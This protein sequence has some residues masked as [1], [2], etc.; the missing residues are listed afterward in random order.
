MKWIRKSGIMIVASC[1]AAGV[2]Q[3][4][5]VI[6][7]PAVLPEAMV[8]VTVSDLHG[9]LDGVGGVAAQVSPMMNGMML[10]NMIGMQLGDPGLAGI[11]PGKGLAVV[12]LD[13]T[14]VFAV[15]EVGEAQIGAY[16]NALAPQGLQ[17]KY[18]NELLIVGK[19]AEQVTKGLGMASAIQT[20]L[21]A[22]RS[23]T[24]RIAA[25]P[26]AIIERNN[27]KIQGL[28]QTMPALMGQGMMQ[29]PGT[30]TNA[31]DS[32]MKILEGEL[33]VL[34]SIAG[35]CESV[36]VVLAPENGSLRIDETFVPK[37]GT[38]LATLC[39]AP[40]VNPPNPRL[41]SGMC[42]E[43]MML[44][45]FV[46]GNPDALAAFIAAETEQLVKAMEITDVDLVGLTE[47]MVKWMSLYCGTGCESV[48]FGADGMNINYLFEIGDEA[49]ALGLLK[50]MQQD[51]APF[52]KLYEDMGMPMSFEFKENVREYKGIKIHTLATRLSMEQMAAEQCAQMGSM[53]L[54]NM[55]YDIAV[56]DGIMIYAM[57]DAKIET[58]IDRLKDDTFKATPLKA[59]SVYPEKGFYYFDLDVGEYIDFIAS[60]MP[61]GTPM[62]NPQMVALFQ[63]V[64]PVTSAGFKAD[65]R[66]MWSANVPGELIAKFGQMAMMAQMQQMQQQPQCATPQEAPAQ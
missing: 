36:E 58:L 3:A 49:A 44:I 28:L 24:L 20:T 15:I 27:D 62:M 60:F 54:T 30:G 26:A 42:G 51:M 61:T 34:L 38:R 6:E 56:T 50:T 64:E 19:T 46:L 41:Q 21:L 59:R 33:L 47:N 7:E 17:F 5:P 14:N 13:T 57:G 40:V 65:G 25:Q 45:D 10:K 48:G 63:G 16:T 9:L 11:A 12:A 29:A 37:A 35:Q 1:L 4:S 52:F 31:V 55:V 23:P 66:V 18:E 39:N 2:L 53:N 8:S 32:T 22:K 43:G